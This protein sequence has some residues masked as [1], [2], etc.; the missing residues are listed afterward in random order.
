MHPGIDE[1]ITR[2]HIPSEVLEPLILH[3]EA[4][5]RCMENIWRKVFPDHTYVYND[6]TLA[7]YQ[8]RWFPNNTKEYCE[9]RAQ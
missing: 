8:V 2:G 5:A 7:G 6:P 3:R 4:I 1:F 9:N